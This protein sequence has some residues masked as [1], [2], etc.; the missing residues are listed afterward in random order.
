M[1]K[2]FDTSTPKTKN[3]WTIA[4]DF[5]GNRAWS[6]AVAILLLGSIG[7]FGQVTLSLSSASAV[8][9]GSVSVDLSMAAG[10]SQP[11]GLQWTY[12]YSTADFS[13]VSVVAGPAAMAAGKSISCSG[14]PGL[15]T[16]LLVG[17]NHSR[18]C[19]RN[20]YVRGVTLDAK[21]FFSYPDN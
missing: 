7:A 17:L 11:V 21:Y 14:A 15:Y 12:S 9:G 8:A 13:S 18:R 1:R 4:A 3:S 5:C 10:A 20:S 19:D 16:C 6:R 2:I